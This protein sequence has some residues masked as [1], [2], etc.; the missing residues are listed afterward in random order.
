VN[1]SIAAVPG[2]SSLGTHPKL[3]VTPKVGNYVFAFRWLLVTRV[4]VGLRED[5][6]MI[7]WSSTRRT[8]KYC[9]RLL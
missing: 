5:A 8:Y 7:V 4:F 2:G 1:S 3:E 9:L 6:D